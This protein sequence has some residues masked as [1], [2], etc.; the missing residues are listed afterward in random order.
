[1][2]DQEEKLLDRFRNPNDPLKILIVTAKLLTGFDAPIL[3]AMYLDKPLRDH[4]L[5]QA[6]CRTNRTYGDKKTHGLIID[7]LG[8][9]DDVAKALEFDE[10]DF[11]K[12]VSGITELA[13]Q[14]PGAVQKCLTYFHGCDRTLTGYEGLIE[15]QDCLPNN[16]VRD[17]FATDY[18]YLAKLWEALSPDT[19]LSSYETD[20]RWLSQVYTSVQPTSGMGRLIWHS[21]GAKTIELIHQNV[22][23]ETIRDDLEAIILDSE[24]VE[25]ILDSPNPDRKA[26]EIQIKVAQRL[27]NHIGNPR[28]KALSE[29]LEALKER[30]EQGQIHSVAFLKEILDLARELLEAEKDTPPENEEDRAKAALTELFQDVS[31]DKTPKI[32]ECIVNDIDEIVRLVRFDGWQNTSA[33]EREVRQALR[34][35]LL[36]YK[37]HQVKELFEKAYGY[38]KQYY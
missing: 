28:F 37:L 30:H 24:L 16:D 23:V 33:G 22:Q 3:Q 25:L 5:L 8:V 34:R 26:K 31:N 9:F 20:Y 18:S 29:R 14:L 36:K 15:A 13:K 12:V 17:A 38:I 35:M 27:R 2:R 6:I 21:L 4:T 10:Q 7:Y 1:T 19:V 11:A 32:V